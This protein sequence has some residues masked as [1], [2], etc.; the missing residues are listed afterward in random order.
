M[1]KKEKKEDLEQDFYQ[2]VDKIR[3][4]RRSFF[5]CQVLVIFLLIVLIGLVVGGWWVIKKLQTPPTLERKVAPVTASDANIRA[6]Y[7]DVLK[8]YKN[9]VEITEGEL[10]GLLASYT[11]IHSDFPLK[12][13]QAIIEPDKI[14]I[15][16]V[17]TSPLKTQ[18]VVELYPQV[19]N[20]ILKMQVLKI[21]AGEVN[22]PS[23]VTKKIE[24]DIANILS[25]AFNQPNFAITNVGL[26]KSKIILEV[27]IV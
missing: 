27:K 7:D 16:G 9:T 20:G 15:S 8:G 25:N 2:D 3:K 23:F 4:G 18:V 6:K 19:E 17:V 5:S 14:K 1:G 22:L 10:T 13:S 12:E 11:V 26:E 21:S 24:Q